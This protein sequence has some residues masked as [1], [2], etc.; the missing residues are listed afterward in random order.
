MADRK[1]AKGEEYFRY[2]EQCL[3]MAKTIADQPSRTLLREMAAE[4][5]NLASREKD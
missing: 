4:W 1:Q 2:A 5:A 3:A